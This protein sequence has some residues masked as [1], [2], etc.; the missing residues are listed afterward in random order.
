MKR[1]IFFDIDGTLTR[2]QNGYVPFNEAVFKTFGI[3]GDIRSVIPDGNTDPRIV[4]DIFAQASLKLAIED[5]QWAEFS[6][7]LR[8]LFERREARCYHDPFP[9]RR[10]D[11]TAPSGRER[12][13]HFQCGDGQFGIRSDR[14][15]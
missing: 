15:A 2:T 11:I 13:L 3:R 5:C 6:A 9:S 10:G 14:K 4:E 12:Q 8:L 1:L 7:N